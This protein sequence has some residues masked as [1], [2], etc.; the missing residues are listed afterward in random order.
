MH[1]P[2]QQAPPRLARRVPPPRRPRR[3]GTSAGD[4]VDWFAVLKFPDG[5]E[6][7]YT[8][9]NSASLGFRKS[10]YTLDSASDGAVA[11]TLGPIYSG[12]SSVGYVQYNDEWPDDNKH[13]TGAHA[14]GVLGFDAGSS[15]GFWLIHSVP[16]FPEYASKGAYPGL[17]DNEYVVESP[18]AQVSSAS[19]PRERERERAENTAVEPGQ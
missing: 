14:K 6:Y 11:S 3:A 15:A 1:C 19:N 10:P 7:A 9:A 8:D 2:R 16:R 18:I 12:D 5:P 17:P 4:P 13:G